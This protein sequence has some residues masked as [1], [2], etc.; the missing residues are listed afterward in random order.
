MTLAD[1]ATLINT[2]VNLTR[3]PIIGWDGISVYDILRDGL[4]VTIIAWFIS[5]VIKGKSAA[6]LVVQNETYKDDEYAWAA[7]EYAG[8]EDVPEGQTSIEGQTENWNQ[9]YS[10]TTAAE[11]RADTETGL[12]D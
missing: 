8:H 3:T 11:A 9:G 12:K 5:R 6:P 4:F 2:G 1:G 7:N 10:E